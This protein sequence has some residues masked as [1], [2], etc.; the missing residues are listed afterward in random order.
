MRIFWKQKYSLNE[1]KKIDILYD[2]LLFY[3]Y[4]IQVLKRNPWYLSA[5]YLLV[6]Y[7]E[8]GFLK[9]GKKLTN[10]N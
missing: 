10:S 7:L 4:L 8:S 9:R 6:L 3:V 5:K 1:E 2:V